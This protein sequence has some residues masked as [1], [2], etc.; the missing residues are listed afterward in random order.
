M[1]FVFSPPADAAAGLLTLP[2]EQP[3]ADWRDKRL[4]EIRQ[5][6]LSRHVVRFVADDGRPGGQEPEAGTGGCAALPVY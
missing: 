2:W 6:G 3:L 4:I 5:R 1:R